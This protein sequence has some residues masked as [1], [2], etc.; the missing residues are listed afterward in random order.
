VMRWHHAWSCSCKGV[1]TVTAADARACPASCLPCLIV[2]PLQ[3]MK[4]DSDK[5]MSVKKLWK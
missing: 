4:K 2:L 3:V 1:Y 5:N